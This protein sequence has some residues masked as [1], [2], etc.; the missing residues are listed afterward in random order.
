MR[1]LFV[2]AIVFSAISVQAGAQTLNNRIIQPFVDG[3]AGVYDALGYKNPVVWGG[4]GV[5]VET[6]RVLILS[7]G[8]AELAR[9]IETGDGYAYHFQGA[10]YARLGAGGRLLAGV[11]DGWSREITSQ[12][13]KSAQRPFIGGGYEGERVRIVLGYSLPMLDRQNG[14]QGVTGDVEFGVGRHFRV[15]LSDGLFE[16]H[17]TLGTTHPRTH[18][19]AESFGGLKFVF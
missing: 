13:S 7:S 1:M 17:D 11:G 2:A 4:G 6:N 9:K 3:E 10:A 18:L 19:G 12:W 16:Y 5:D 15:L 8:H 14:L